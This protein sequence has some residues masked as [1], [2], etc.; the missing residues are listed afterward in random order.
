MDTLMNWIHFGLAFPLFPTVKIAE[1]DDIEQRFASY[2]EAIKDIP[3]TTLLEVLNIHI[4]TSTEALW[5]VA[6]F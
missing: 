5:S 3:S 1:T 6:Y 4:P 2:S